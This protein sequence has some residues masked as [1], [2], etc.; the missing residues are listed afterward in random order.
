MQCVKNVLYD[1]A[2]LTLTTMN[3]T[4]VRAPLPATCE[5]KHRQEGC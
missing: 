5:R 3:V 2:P 4:D 1:T